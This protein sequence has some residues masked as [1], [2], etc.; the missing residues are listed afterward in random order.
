MTFLH[1]IH[2][3]TFTIRNQLPGQNINLIFAIMICLFFRLF[4]TMLKSEKSAEYRVSSEKFE[5]LL[6]S[7]VVAADWAEFVG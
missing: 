7:V 1:S 2:L 5:D 6:G 3:L 4:S